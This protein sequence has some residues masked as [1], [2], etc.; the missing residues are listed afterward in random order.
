MVTQE[1]GQPYL[2]PRRRRGLLVWA[3]ADTA[4]GLVL[5]LGGPRRVSSHAF[6]PAKHL[7][8]MTAWGAVA[9]VIGV[10]W[11]AVV[12]YAQRIPWPLAGY[13]IGVPALLMASWHA[14]FC[15]S[16]L[17]AAS[18]PVVALTGIPIYAAVTANHYLFAVD[19]V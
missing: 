9:L 2:H 16:L 19:Q 1:D 18:N 4:L 14:F 17:F 15:T 5:V 13:L 8:P 12:L 6:D 7:A 11:L 3:V 10:C